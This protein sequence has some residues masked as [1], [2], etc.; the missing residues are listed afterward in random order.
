MPVFLRQM[1][2]GS[3]LSIITT[4]IMIVAFTGFGLGLSLASER[5]L[6]DQTR[7]AMQEQIAQFRQTV[8]LF[9][10]SLQQQAVRFLSLFEGEMLYPPF[11][12]DERQ[13]MMVG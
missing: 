11:V 12:L 10:Q 9:D 7:S 6:R 8:A 13:S 1:N 4:L 3:R 5:L 2:I